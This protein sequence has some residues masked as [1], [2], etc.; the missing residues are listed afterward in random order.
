M[1]IPPVTVGTTLELVYDAAVSG[2]FSGTIQKIGGVSAVVAIS[3]T[4][5]PTAPI[6]S[7]H[8]GSRSEE[9]SASGTQKIFARGQYNSVTVQLVEVGA[10][11]GAGFALGP[12]NNIF[13]TTGSS[14]DTDLSTITVAA[15]RA[16]AE[17]TRNTY[18]TANSGW[19]DGYTDLDVNVILYY[20]D[21][22]NRVAQY[23][24]RIGSN[25]VD[26]GPPV[27]ALQG[28]PGTPGGTMPVQNAA[29]NEILRLNAA[30][31]ALEGTGVF[32][33]PTEGEISTEKSAKFGPGSVSLGD[34]V[35]IRSASR[36]V[37]FNDA[38]GRLGIAAG[39]VYD[40]ATGSLA[41]RDLNLAAAVDSV[42]GSNFST[43]LSD[44]FTMQFGVGTA[45]GLTLSYQV[46]PTAVGTL[47]VQSYYGTSTSDP[48]IVDRSF[49]ITQQ[50]VDN[51]ALPTP[52]GKTIS[53]PNPTYTLA[54]D[55]THTVFSGVALR[56]GP[57]P[58]LGGLTN[59]WL[60]VRGSL[61]D[62]KEVIS[63][64]ADQYS[65][66]TEKATAVSADTILIEDS[67]DSGEKKRLPVSGLP[68]PPPASNTDPDAVHLTVANEINGIAAKTAAVG[69]DIVI[70]ED[71]ENSFGKRKM[72]LAN[73]VALAGGTPPPTPV[74]TDL[75]YG[76]STESDPAS[77]DFNSLTDVASPTDPITVST[78][79]TS[80]GQY[81]HIFTSNTHEIV[82]ITDTVLQQIVYQRGGSGNIFTLDEDNRTEGSVTYD[83]LTIGPL[84]AGVDEEYVVRFS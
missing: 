50:D 67:E 62:P 10:V 47:R 74:A 15:D 43:V 77:V 36:Q 38:A 4:N 37:V 70:I 63:G 19:I 76:L 68:I 75:R 41:I 60:I 24:R 2:P 61:A 81:F 35:I 5:P 29:A 9:I 54:N 27:L 30:G 1:A 83:A 6:S 52:V 25:W 56:G 11:G 58:E 14:G 66:I 31:T 8:L 49:D 16:T 71:S 42:V 3:D 34:S 55:N 79:V 72:T 20:M 59:P 28:D 84:N 33:D 53:I 44:P 51:A 40:E 7:L 69:A 26:N 64:R 23:Q 82:S 73:L 21:S 13:G 12:A 65:S 18:D 80:A 32:A 78:G 45:E 48:V 39:M 17:A 46:L 57:Q 22:G